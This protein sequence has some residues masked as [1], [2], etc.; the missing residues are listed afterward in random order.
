MYCF[1]C[2][3][4]LCVESGLFLSSSTSF[5]H[6]CGSFIQQDRREKRFKTIVFV[7]GVVIVVCLFGV[8]WFCFLISKTVRRYSVSRENS[9][10]G[11]DFIKCEKGFYLQSYLHVTS[12][13]TWAEQAASTE[14]L[15]LS[16]AT[17][18]IL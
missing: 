8:F 7:A 5:S 14:M 15:H 12:R 9:S 4:N 11:N 1:T 2:K 17:H 18:D 13:A 10:I 6:L 3:T 16:K